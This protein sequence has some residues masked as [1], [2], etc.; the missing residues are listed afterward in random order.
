MNIKDLPQHQRPPGGISRQQYTYKNKNR[1]G[2]D[3]NLFYDI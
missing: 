1:K 3:R 2:I